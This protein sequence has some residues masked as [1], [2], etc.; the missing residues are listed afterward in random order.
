M[1]ELHNN[2]LQDIKTE[3]ISLS[4]SDAEIKRLLVKVWK[5]QLSMDFHIAAAYTAAIGQV[6]KSEISLFALLPIRLSLVK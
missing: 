2:S 4:V 3:M 6:D 5:I 1:Y